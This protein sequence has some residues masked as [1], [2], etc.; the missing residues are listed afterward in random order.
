MWK[1]IRYH[2]VTNFWTT[3]QPISFF[4]TY[5]KLSSA[6]DIPIPMLLNMQCL[7]KDLF[8]E[9]DSNGKPHTKTICCYHGPN[10]YQWYIGAWI[11]FSR[12][13]VA[14]LIEPK[15]DIDDFSY[16]MVSI[17]V[18]FESNYLVNLDADLGLSHS[19]LL[20]CRSSVWKG[21]CDRLMATWVIT[22]LIEMRFHWLW[23]E[24]L[25]SP[26]VL[27]A[28]LHMFL[29]VYF[30][31]IVELWVVVSKMAPRS[32]LFFRSSNKWINT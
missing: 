22:Y 21:W 14:A 23:K 24:L 26:L 25:F 19:R 12:K 13:H 20:F 11:G 10:G 32:E 4:N 15:I 8:L 9:D 17:Y 6:L 2:T 28:R 1:N 29:M 7:Q 30:H 31:K 5:D 18:D 3:T 27:L 16:V